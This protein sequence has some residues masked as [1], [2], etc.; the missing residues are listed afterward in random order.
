MKYVAMALMTAALAFGQAKPVL[1][2]DL[3]GVAGKEVVMLTLDVAPGGESAAHRH[4]ANTFVYVLEGQMVM[5]VKGGNPVTI[6][7]GETFYE[8]PDDVH[9]VSKNASSTKPAKILVFFVKEKGA[10]QTVPAK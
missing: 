8:S 10:P 4:N 3:A 1:T 9:A 2:K 6:G 5:A 7:P